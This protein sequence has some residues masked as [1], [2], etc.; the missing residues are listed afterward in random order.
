MFY[1]FIS[2]CAALIAY[3]G[4]KRQKCTTL[5]DSKLPRAVYETSQII[6][7]CIEH[8]VVVFHLVKH[9]PRQ[10][11]GARRI[12]EIGCERVIVP[13]AEFGGWQ[14]FDCTKKCARVAR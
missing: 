5:R 11:L 7:Q 14:Y 3:S 12:S 10:S 8:S 6:F 4:S 1:A 9:L 13:V 2:K